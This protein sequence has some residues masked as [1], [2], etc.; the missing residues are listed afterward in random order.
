MRDREDQVKGR[1]QFP[2]ICEIRMLIQM[3]PSFSFCPYSFI[4]CFWLKRTVLLKCIFAWLV[5]KRI[6]PLPNC[7]FY[8]QR[9]CIYNWQI[10]WSAKCNWRTP[11]CCVKKKKIKRWNELRI[12]GG[13]LKVEFWIESK[14]E[15]NIVQNDLLF[16]L[17]LFLLLYLVLYIYN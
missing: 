4:A 11:C 16:S 5:A 17:S 2:L 7:Q 12:E 15:S 14:R 9:Q 1:G 6:C 10:T 3:L 13:G 8:L